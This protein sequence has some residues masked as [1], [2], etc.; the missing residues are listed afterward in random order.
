MERI[1]EFLEENKVLSCVL[2]VVIAIACLIGGYFFKTNDS[3][4]QSNSIVRANESSA[5][6]DVSLNSPQES[7][8]QDNMSKNFFVDIKGAVKK[9]GIYKVTHKMRVAN[10]ISAAGGLE[11]TADR[12]QI[13]LALKLVDQQVIYVPF[14]GEIDK[15]PPTTMETG[16]ISNNNDKNS[17]TINSEIAIEESDAQNN[18]KVDLNKVTKSELL[19]LDG[20]GDKKADLILTYRTQ[21]GRFE[22]IEELMDITGIGDKTFEK[23]KE[24]LTIVP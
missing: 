1:K 2:V 6:K 24:R 15:K 21:H 12:N 8:K 3:V 9:P 16:Q 23:L 19:E 14:K 4:T 17:T 7:A 22:K 13:N 18:K 20:I 11:K 10:V 5:K